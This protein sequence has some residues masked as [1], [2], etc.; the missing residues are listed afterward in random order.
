MIF[1][2]K[3][4]AIFQAILLEKIPVF[5][6]SSFFQ[7]L[8]LVLGIFLVLLSPF[9]KN[10]TPRFFFLFL[11]FFILFKEIELFF[12]FKI[13]NPKLKITLS[14]AI[15]RPEEYNLAEFLDFET[16][17]IVWQSI[18]FCKK[19]KISEIPSAVL[20][21]FSLKES[22]RI[23]FIF[24]RL[25]VNIFSLEEK[26]KNYLEKLERGEEFQEKFSQNFQKTIVEAL[27]FANKRRE[28]KIGIRE[29]LIG[30]SKHEP[31]FEKILT[32][33]ALTCQD[34]ENTVSWSHFL[35]NRII[36]RKKF[37]EYE[38]LAKH[39]SLARDWA[40][41]YTI[42][43]DKF[44]IDWTKIVKKWIL[45]EIIGHQKEIKLVERIL[46][47]PKMNNVL[48]IGEPG[49]GRKS[50]VEAIAYKIFVGASFPELNYQRVVEL[51]MVS[52]F[53]QIPTTEE[54]EVVLRK[55]FQ[56][57]V[58]A[59]NVIL[60]I[61]NLH[62]YVGGKKASLGTADI[63]EILAKYLQFPQFR[64][65]GI[66]DYNGL[67]RQIEQNPSLLSL[68]NKVEVSE[69][70]EAETIRVLRNHA[71]ELEERYKIFVTYPTI[72]EII[73][74]TDRYMPSHYFPEKAINILEE[75]VIYV[76]T[77]LKEKMV[78]PSHVAKVVSE[79][80]EIP[81]GE[82][83]EKEKE[84][85]LNLEKLI[86]QRIINQ[87]EAVKEVST[88]LRRTRA[89]IILRKRPIGVFLFLGPTGVGKT[90][91]SKA[92]AE[93]YFKGEENMIRLDMS[94]FQD[95]S[96]IPRLIGKPGQEGILTTSVRE[97]PFSLILLDEIEKAHPDI[98]N[99]FLQVFDEGHITAGDG[100][101][102]VFT[103]TIIICTSNA[104]SGIIFEEIK[105]KK[106]LE[107]IKERLLDY[108]IKNRIFR[109]E[110]INRYDAVIVFK[111]LSKENL[112]D[113]AHLMLSKLK[114]NLEE[115]KVE[116]IITS[117]LKEKIVELSY[118]PVF[119]AREMR[120]VIQ[121]KIENVLAQAFLSDKIKIGDKVMIDPLDFK[122]LIN[123]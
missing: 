25:G 109:A 24:H 41:G 63:S 38:N 36:K 19:R 108:F 54:V 27:K 102:V 40:S 4:S 89:G 48:L 23:K 103:N 12:N 64:L 97:N 37:W 70:S 28:E 117:A 66:C 53:S 20:L 55:I 91:T 92:L 45:K 88:A 8:F 105:L 84:I 33:Y 111:P 83:E 21:Y 39:G 104:G 95:I 69:I 86:H 2:L 1:N 16:A 46:V 96:D 77:S 34:I 44:S 122:L 121:D 65:I 11:I 116:L 114:K 58:Y 80:T 74:L 49:M 100:K 76:V 93:V 42:T 73:K 68:F 62:K 71:L 61:D 7:K 115:K 18:K 30:I 75:T 87:E 10:L 5:R 106:N 31:L 81:V 99:L 82:I 79:K 52:L 6:Y 119:G 112:L 72:R 32:D 9:F 51:D 59:G 56:E 123:P 35:E 57:V 15:S 29:I 98:L 113:I 60:V 26:V 17:K 78:L 13:K 14:Q 118:N 22:K 110:F 3:N 67:H 43:L 90:E 101:K 50:I 120:R 107:T 85:L 47:N 94:E